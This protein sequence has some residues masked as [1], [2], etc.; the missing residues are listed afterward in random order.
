MLINNRTQL[1]IDLFTKNPQ[2]PCLLYGDSGSGLQK[3][4]SQIALKCLGIDNENSSLI[5][6]ITPLEDKSIGID[7]IKEL[8][9]TLSL[10]ALGD[11]NISRAILIYDFQKATDDAQNS[12]LKLLEE[13]PKQTLIILI[14]TDVSSAL[15][16]IVSRCFLLPVLLSS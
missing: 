8:K 12:L 11:S 7:Q 13:L 14:S 6:K 15:D 4:A 2:Q 5:T 3:I 1:L 10:S 16:T 9:A